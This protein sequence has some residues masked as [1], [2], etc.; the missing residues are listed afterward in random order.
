MRL[1]HWVASPFSVRAV[2]LLGPK[3]R[4]KVAA[5][6]RPWKE[7]RMDNGAPKVRYWIGCHGERAY[8]AQCRTFGAL[9]QF[10]DLYPGLTA[11]AIGLPVLRTSLR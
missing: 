5:A 8:D 4:Q 2:T 10:V 1:S 9:F 6:V 7:M 3:G 11:G